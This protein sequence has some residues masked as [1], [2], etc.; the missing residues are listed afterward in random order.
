MPDTL[1]KIAGACAHWYGDKTALIFKDKRLTFREMD[2]LSNKMGNSLREM[3]V[4]KG[5][6]VSLYSQ[7]CWEWIIGY[8][9]AHKIGAVANP[10]NVMLTPEEVLYV[11]N[12]CGA[13]ALITS[14]DKADGVLSIMDK[15]ESL[16]HLVIYGEEAPTK[17]VPFNH[18]LEKGGEQLELE[19]VS[20]DDLST[21]G[22]TS[23]TTGHPKGAMLSN[24]GVV[25]NSKLTAN[26]HMKTHEDVVVTCLPSAHVYGNVVMNGTFLTGGT[27]VLLDRFIEQEVFDAITEH[28]ATVFEGVP[29]MYIMMLNHSG[30]NDCDFSNMT[31]NTVGGQ[32]ISKKVMEDVEERFGS[33]LIE[34]WGMTEISGLGTTHPLLGENRHGS[35]G[36]PLPYCAAKI[37]DPE[38]ASKELGPDEP[39]EFMIKGPIVMQGYYGR[40]EA[41]KETIEPDG[42]L[43]TGDIATMDA[44]GY[45]YIVD[46]KKDMILTGGYNIYPAEIELVLQ[47]HPDVAI[48]AVGAVPDDVKGELA[49]A[50]VVPM[51]GAKPSDEELIAYCREHLAPYK[52]PRLVSFVD[53]LPKTST[54]KIMRRELHTLDK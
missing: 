8:Y 25:I 41:T 21:I 12:D 2:T 18:L 36:I 47:Q 23:G 32:T 43:H 1:G 7:N 6:R 10:V 34:L 49:K 31:K 50:Y 22:Y 11:A 29:A 42:W 30:I 20:P 40:E 5:D 17:A 44:D 27:F 3:G 46:R 28:K 13:S 15:A 38:D 9:A 48:V 53:D 52:V 19:T 16:E 37:V 4:K 24:R 26:M 45:I 39:G 54:G 33:P 14:P 35:I 51:E